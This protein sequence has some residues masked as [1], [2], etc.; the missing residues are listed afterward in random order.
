V[1]A[2]A[3]VA[4]WLLGGAV[5]YYSIG[6]CSTVP[7]LQD[8]GSTID[9]D[10]CAAG[11]TWTFAQSFYFSVQTGLSIGFGLLAESKKV[12]EAYSC[13]H[14]LMGSSVIAG[15]LGLFAQL[16]LQRQ[17]HFQSFEEQRL[18]K[19]SRAVHTNCYSDFSTE[20]L[21]D[22]M[23]EY[24]YYASAVIRK[25]YDPASAE[26]LVRTFAEAGKE[27]RRAE[28]VRI[29]QRAVA[30]VEEFKDSKITVEELQAIDDET[31]D[32]CTRMRRY[33]RANRNFL[34][35]LVSFVSWIALGTLF[36]CLADKNPLVTGVYFAVSTLST[37]GMVAVKTVESQGHVLFAAFYALTGVQ[38]YCLFLGM[39]A[40]VLV[41]RYQQG[42]F[43]EALQQKIS[44]TEA[45][46]LKQ[47]VDH[48]GIP[49]VD[50][51]EFLQFQMLRMGVIDRGMMEE[52]RKQWSKL[53]TEGTGR[54]PKE[55]FLNEME[56]S[57][58]R[59]LARERAAVPSA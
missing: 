8:D 43:Q 3:G 26:V 14:I 11:E 56:I 52:V 39:F 55:T 50:F 7:V 12:S 9:H 57:Q 59:Q 5:V 47:M 44:K 24:P 23:V 33:V 2:A 30:T 22:L 36:S 31:A 48:D 16:A 29:L 38:V 10:Q 53:D 1:I 20:E 46:F 34:A 21:Q 19:A 28:A 51:A 15:A 13:F 35:A 6:N 40:G 27:T 41:E 25:V 32:R 45:E 37:A 58:V 17:E 54:V 4:V 42:Q 49:D 18:A